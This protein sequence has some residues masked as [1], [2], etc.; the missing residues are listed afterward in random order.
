MAL[1]MAAFSVYLMIKSAELPIGWIP[2]SGPGGGAFP[3]WLSLG[4]LLSS[5]WTLVR[6]VR[7][8]SPFSTSDVPYLDRGA[9]MIFLTVA[10]S[11]VVM[12]ALI[13][14]VG[15]YVSVPLF[16]LFYMKVL[17]R[18]SWL[19]CGAWAVLSPIAIFLF[20]ELALSI[21]LPKGI[22]EPAFYPIYDLVY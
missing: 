3:F 2:D 1:V 9:L 16:L 15:I 7:R 14:V 20:F 4:M 10:G 5:L 12:V 11:I 8:T 18:H 13:H 19:L 6:W 21:T 22:T 17:G